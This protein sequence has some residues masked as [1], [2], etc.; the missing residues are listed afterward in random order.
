MTTINRNDFLFGDYPFL[1]AMPGDW[2]KSVIVFLELPNNGDMRREVFMWLC[3]NVDFDDWQWVRNATNRMLVGV[4]FKYRADA[5]VFK[6]RPIVV[7]NT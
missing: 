7:C 1:S 5:V 4:E 3:D 6:L 2:T